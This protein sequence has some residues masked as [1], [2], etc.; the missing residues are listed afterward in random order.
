MFCL[1][2][3]Q[4]HCVRPLIIMFQTSFSSFQ[5]KIYNHELAQQVNMLTKRIDARVSN[6]SRSHDRYEPYEKPEE[7]I[8]DDVDYMEMHNL[9]E[10]VKVACILFL[11]MF[12]HLFKLKFCFIRAVG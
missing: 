7:K 9:K 6:G 12:Q 3:G 8:S 1:F 10:Q 11:Y 2:V 4:D 5:M